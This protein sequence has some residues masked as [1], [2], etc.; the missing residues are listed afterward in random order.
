MKKKFGAIA[1]FIGAILLAKSCSSSTDQEG[2]PSNPEEGQKYSR[3]DGSSG[4]WNAM[5]GYWMISSMINGR[6]VQ[7]HYYPSTN[8]FTNTT[9]QKITKPSYYTAPK[10]TSRS[11]GFGRSG[12]KSSS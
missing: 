6:Q 5:M 10:S 9:G 4:V 2:W 12:T 3:T 8:T 1:L 7:N 11:S